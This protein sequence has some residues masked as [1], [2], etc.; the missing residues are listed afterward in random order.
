MLEIKAQDMDFENLSNESDSFAADSG[1]DSMVSLDEDDDGD[2]GLMHLSVEV[3]ELFERLLSWL[4]QVQQ[5][6]D[7]SQ[8]WMIDD[9]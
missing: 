3:V 7:I 9:E 6:D 2:D 8:D 4:D 1:Y 5:N